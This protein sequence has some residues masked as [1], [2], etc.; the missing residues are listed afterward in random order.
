MRIAFIIVCFAAIGVVLVQFRAEEARVRNETL[1]LRNY[2]D[3]EVPRQVWTQDV[4]ISRLASFRQVG[5]RG[6][7]VAAKLIDPTHRD[8][9]AKGLK[10]PE[11]TRRAVVQRREAAP[12]RETTT[13]P[14]RNDRPILRGR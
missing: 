4:E 5:E 8:A 1:S 12:P 14:Q 7:A 6:E 13:P 2:C 9:L 11:P 10:A 3:I